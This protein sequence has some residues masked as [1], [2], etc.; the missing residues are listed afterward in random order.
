MGIG[1]VVLP[2]FVSKLCLR[3]VQFEVGSGLRTGM[4]V[5]RFSGGV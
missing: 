2:I 4:L 1:L 3:Y 5:V